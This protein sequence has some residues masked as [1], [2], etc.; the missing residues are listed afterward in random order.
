MSQA[1]EEPVTNI[2]ESLYSEAELKRRWLK[3]LR[4]HTIYC[5]DRDM[6][7]LL[8]WSKIQS[9][10]DFYS[11]ARKEDVLRVQ[12]LIEDF[13]DTLKE[14]MRPQA[15]SAIKTFLERNGRPMSSLAVGHFP[16]EFHR[17]YK[18][19]EIQQLMS[20][21]DRDIEKLYCLF[22]KDSGL[23]SFHL[24]ALRPHHFR[25]DMEAGQSFWH[26]YLEPSF[27][28]GRKTA[29]LTFLGPNSIELL[30]RMITDGKISIPSVNCKRE[31]CNCR[32]LFPFVRQSWRDIITAAKEKAGL[33]P[34]IQPNHGFRK[35]FKNALDQAGIDEDK[36]RQLQGHSLGTEWHYTDRDVDDLRILY[37][38]A[39]PFLDLSEKAAVDK[40]ARE[41]RELVVELESENRVL[42]LRLAGISDSE[43]R[44]HA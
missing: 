25:P 16:V 28:R 15:A 3:K 17:G 21:L 26:L 23:R 22:A 32:P 1:F 27:Y 14:S 37:K 30:K 13:V 33:D 11:W 18:R 4:P 20:Y 6:K 38:R 29:G 5:Y 36:K 9:I 42:K 2:S 39:F 10:Q 35:F 31:N 44:D 40:S 19:H 34:I 8:A 43:Q 24:L 7:R 41:L 12:D